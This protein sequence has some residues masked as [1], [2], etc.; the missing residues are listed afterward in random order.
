MAD[1]L[2]FQAVRYGKQ[3]ADELDSLICP[4]YDIISPEEQDSFYET[5]PLNIIRL[6]LGKQHPDD[7]PEHDRY[8]RAAETL[9]T[10]LKDGVLEH[11][12]S[13]GFTVYQMEYTL[14]D[15]GTRV[16]D[17][18]ISLVRVGE[19]GPGKVLPHEKTYLGP[20]EDQLKLLRACHA[21][22]TPI[23]AL[24]SDEEGLVSAQYKELIESSPD[25]RA[26]LGDGV[27]HRTWRLEDKAA[28][29]KIV[30]TIKGSSLLIADGHHRYET[31]LA[32][33]DEMRAK[34]AAQADGGHEFVM[35]Y[36][37]SMS[38]PGLTVLPAHRMIDRDGDLNIAEAIE[39]IENYFEIEQL[40]YSAENSRQV[41]EQL[42]SKISESSSNAGIMGIA[43]R[44]EPCFRL[45][46]VKDL[47]KVVAEIDPQIPS[48]IRSL[49]VTILRE[50]VMGI[51]FGIDAGQSEGIIDYTPSAVDALEKVLK[52]EKQVSF[53][54]NPTR[55]DQVRVAAELGHKL[56]HKSTYF[57]PKISSGLVLRTLG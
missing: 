32:F 2:P 55:V 12:E 51:G 36:L 45:I 16:V 14:P 23:H 9:R 21:N 54:I 19:Y 44:N 41:A 34:G 33:R 28:L 52:G 4:P 46:R 13:P 40:D 35:M 25:R 39:R 27:I 43:V 11:T 47:D 50:V 24:F 15:G 37:T 7:T 48:A 22:F 6:V 18:I 20:K 29:D 30:E 31:A 57:Y 26:T 3:Y 17:G 38:H 5:H 56:P 42:I 10:W 1:I 53:I 49:D 8:T